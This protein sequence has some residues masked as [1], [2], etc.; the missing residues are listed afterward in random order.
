MNGLRVLLLLLLH[1]LIFLCLHILLHLLSFSFFSS[2]SRTQK[3][4]LLV[5]VVTAFLSSN[6]TKIVESSFSIPFKIISHACHD[7]S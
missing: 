6:K 1:I 5:V 7:G 3:A 2:D 4:S